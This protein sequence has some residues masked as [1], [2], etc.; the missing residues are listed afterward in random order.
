M[1]IIITIIYIILYNNNF[2]IYILENISDLI[3]KELTTIDKYKVTLTEVDINTLEN[4]KRN[5][6]QKK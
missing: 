5:Y 6:E 4:F 2:Y 3:E 1:V